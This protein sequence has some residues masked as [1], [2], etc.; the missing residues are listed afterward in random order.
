M[1][2]DVGDGVGVAKTRE[3]CVLRKLQGPGGT[4]K[5]RETLLVRS[6]AAS[7]FAQSARIPAPRASIRTNPN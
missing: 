6:A 3:P 2:G 1:G 7:F 4:P 5:S